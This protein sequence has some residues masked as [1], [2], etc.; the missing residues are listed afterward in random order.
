M[1]TRPAL[2]VKELPGLKTDHP[3]K[4]YS[5]GNLKA[6]WG[7]IGWDEDDLIRLKLIKDPRYRE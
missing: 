2:P 7:D 5:P 4:S 1:E 6:I 3:K